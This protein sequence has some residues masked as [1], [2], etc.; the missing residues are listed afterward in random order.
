MRDLVVVV[1]PYAG[2]HRGERV[3]QSLQVIDPR[4]REARVVMSPDPAHAR[5]QLAGMLDEGLDRVLVVG[6]DGTLHLVANAILELGLGE[7]VAIGVVP[8]GT[9]SDLARSL[10]VPGRPAAALRFALAAEPQPMDVLRVATDDGRGE[11]V[12]NVASAGIS[13]LVDEAVNRIQRRGALAYLGASLGAVWRYRPV[14]CRVAVDGAEWYDGAVLL[15]AVANGSTFGN[16]MRIAPG[17][18]VD[19]G[20][21]D[22]ILVRPVPRWQLLVRL[23]QIYLGTHVRAGFVQ[24]GRGREVRVEPQAPLPPF[25]L[26]G[27]AVESAAATITVVPGALQLLR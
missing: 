6:G 18:V 16:G 27:E 12:L 22:V 21:A 24:V 23:P 3:W 2:S 9:G 14:R 8:T 11:Y 20:L 26:D 5:G 13:G 7:E 25:D 15:L 4:L 17:A 1:N 19:D 10:G